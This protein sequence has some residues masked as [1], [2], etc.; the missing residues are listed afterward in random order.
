M[1]TNHRPRLRSALLVVVGDTPF[2]AVPVQRR[3]RRFLDWVWDWVSAVV[4]G[5]ARLGMEVEMGM[6]LATR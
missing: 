1:D 4:Q 3:D 5:S 2:G 6:G